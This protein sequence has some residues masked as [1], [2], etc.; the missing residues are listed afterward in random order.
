MG[1]YVVTEPLQVAN[2]YEVTADTPDE[3][4]ALV[5]AGVYDHVEMSDALPNAPMT[6]EAIP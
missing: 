1:R 3:A 5:V 6:A 4:I 2:L